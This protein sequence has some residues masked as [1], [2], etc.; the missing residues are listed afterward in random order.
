[1]KKIKINTRT[2]ND[3]ILFRQVIQKADFQ[4]KINQ[5]KE[6]DTRRER[7]TISKDERSVGTK[8]AQPK[9]IYHIPSKRVI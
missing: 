2:I 7:T 1:M 9:L 5:C 4:E 8:D 6:A 3:R